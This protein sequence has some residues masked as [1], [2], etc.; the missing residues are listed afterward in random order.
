MTIYYLHTHHLAD[1][2][3]EKKTN[4]VA[5]LMKCYFVVFLGL[6]IFFFS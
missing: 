3:V 4:P 6:I 2:S 1:I 5:I